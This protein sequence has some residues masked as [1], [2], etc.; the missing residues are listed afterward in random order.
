[1]TEE[2]LQ[3]IIFDAFYY[4]DKLQKA[5]K[6]IANYVKRLEILESSTCENCKWCY[7]ISNGWLHCKDITNPCCDVVVYKDFG[8]N[9]FEEKDK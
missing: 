3:T 7:K 8:C 1:M 6:R 5:N 9:K 2:R 4:K